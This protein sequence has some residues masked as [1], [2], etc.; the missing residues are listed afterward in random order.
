M[1]IGLGFLMF[2]PCFYQPIEDQKQFVNVDIGQGN[3]TTTRVHVIFHEDFDA[4]LP[5]EDFSISATD[6]RQVV[7]RIPNSRHL[8]IDDANRQIVPN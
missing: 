4:F 2:P 8:P 3:R 7:C 5:A 6:N 1:A